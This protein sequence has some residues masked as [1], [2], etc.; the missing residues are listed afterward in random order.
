MYKAKVTVKDLDAIIDA[1]NDWWV[2]GSITGRKVVAKKLHSL[3]IFPG[4][5]RAAYRATKRG[6]VAC[7]VYAG[8]TPS[9]TYVLNATGNPTLRVN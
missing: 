1:T 9:G 8:P 2:N 7:G 3:F 6:Y 5:Y 4:G